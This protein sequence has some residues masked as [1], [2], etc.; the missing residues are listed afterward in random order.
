MQYVE[1]IVVLDRVR[2]TKFI[3]DTGAMFTCCNYK[4]FDS[5]IDEGTLKENETKPVHGKSPRTISI[6]SQ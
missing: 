2:A 6:F 1:C 5:R 3:V 4:V